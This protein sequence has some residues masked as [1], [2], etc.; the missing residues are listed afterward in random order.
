ML[1]WVN[2]GKPL[3]LSPCHFPRYKVRDWIVVSRFAS[4]MRIPR[5][6]E[7]GSYFFK[8]PIWGGWVAGTWVLQARLLILIPTRVWE[9]PDQITSEG[10][11]Q[12]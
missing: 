6:Q 11:F 4:G 12:P 5:G 3:L 9:T 7:R 8:I 10:S 2:L 1:F